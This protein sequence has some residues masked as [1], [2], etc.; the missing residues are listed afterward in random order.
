MCSYLVAWDGLGQLPEPRPCKRAAVD[1]SPFCRLHAMVAARTPHVEV[2]DGGFCVWCGQ[3]GRSYTADRVT[4]TLCERHGKA[5]G[6]A[7]REGR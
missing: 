3:S 4:I 6:R 2:R 1:D 5:L 7:L